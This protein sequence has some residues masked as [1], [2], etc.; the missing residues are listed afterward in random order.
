MNEDDPTNLELLRISSIDGFYEELAN[1]PETLHYNQANEFFNIL[2]SYF[3][4]EVDE[5]DGNLI[6]MTIAK[7]LCNDRHLN[8]FI[9]KGYLLQLPFKQKQF[10]DSVFDILYVLVNLNPYCFEDDEVTKAFAPMIRKNP[11]KALTLIAIFA[12]KF[13]EID[14]PWP[15][16]DLLIQE[17]S[18]FQGIEIASNYVALVTSLC[19]KYQDYCLGRAEHCWRKISALLKETDIITLRTVYCGLCNIARV[20]SKPLSLP[21]SLIKPHLRVKEL[22]KPILTLLVTVPL[23]G[24]ECCDPTLLQ[25]LCTL[26]ERD[27]K[28]SLVLMKAAEDEEFAQFMVENSEFWMPKELPTPLD[29]LRLFLVIFKRASLREQIADSK[30]FTEF[31]KMA[32]EQENSGTLSMICTIV[33]RVNIDQAKIAAMSDSGFLRGF[34][35][36]AEE[37][38]NSIATHSA[39]LMLDTLARVGYTREYMKM[40]DFV[41]KIVVDRGELAEVAALVAVQLCQYK[42]CALAFK[43]RRLDEFMKTMLKDSQ[44]RR[45]A[46]RFIDAISYLNTK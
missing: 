8:V 26:A 23:S 4:T 5:Y 46:A 29:S 22:Q 31:L 12:D 45:A 30:C 19:I 37:I 40:C 11:K 9:S 6:L 17:A 16:V 2:L 1:A 13:N 15:M 27:E 39:L 36:T 18:R 34:F 14:N 7:V 20:Y 44:L 43:R 41:S 24:P 33:R 21:I 38:G 35:S 28:A 42:K 32:T 3:R 10:Q 25:A